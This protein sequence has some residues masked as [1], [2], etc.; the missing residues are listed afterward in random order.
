MSTGARF[1]SNSI[2]GLV[3]GHLNL[4]TAD[5]PFWRLCGFQLSAQVFH[6][7]RSIEQGFLG[8]PGDIESSYSSKSDPKLV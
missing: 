5:A 8:A 6:L 3:L 2:T 4:S 1:L 7:L